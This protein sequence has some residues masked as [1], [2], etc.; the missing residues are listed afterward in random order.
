MSAPKIMG[1]LIRGP[2]LST[3]RTIVEGPVLGPVEDNPH[4]A[5]CAEC[6]LLKSRD[7]MLLLHGP[8]KATIVYATPQCEPEPAPTAS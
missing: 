3:I 2:G 4:V 6:R 7:R 8:M 1:K 5:R